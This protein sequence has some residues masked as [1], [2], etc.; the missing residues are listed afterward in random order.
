ML[1]QNEHTR[2]L[3][4]DDDEPEQ[5]IKLYPAEAISW[6]RSNPSPLRS[7]RLSLTQTADACP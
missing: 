2:T 7:L 6:M 3:L 1:N 4:P 5:L